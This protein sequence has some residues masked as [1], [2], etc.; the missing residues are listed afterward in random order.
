RNYKKEVEEISGGKKNLIGELIIADFPQL[1][2]ISIGLNQLTQL[3]LK[4]CPQLIK[5]DCFDNK[6]T[7]LTI[8][9]CPNLQKIYADNNQLTS[10]D[11]SHN[12]Q[13]TDLYCDYSL[14]PNVIGLEKTSIVRLDVRRGLNQ[15]EIT[16]PQEI[17]QILIGV[18][19]I[20]PEMKLIDISDL[21]QLA[22]QVNK[23][24][25]YDEE[26]LKQICPL[27]PEDFG[28]FIKQKK[29]NFY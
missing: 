23:K 28:E 15:G 9:N 5:L 27:E 3:H 17:W 22:V 11:V 24:T 7:E 16:N 13:L 18:K 19:E 26:F 1:E 14:H 10:L 4:N 12:P 6:L 2:E 29:G 20:F 25:A 8:T 21:N